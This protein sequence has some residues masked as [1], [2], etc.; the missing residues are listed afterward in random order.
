MILEQRLS[1]AAIYWWIEFRLRKRYIYLV[2]HLNS[3]EHIEVV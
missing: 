3:C 2:I 1:D